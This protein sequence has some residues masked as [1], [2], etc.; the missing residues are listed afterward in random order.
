MTRAYNTATTQQNSGGA[1]PTFNAGKNK[2]ING[3]FA[4]WQRNTTFTGSGAIYTAD[5]F[6]GLSDASQTY[7]R[8]AFTPGAAPVTGY[9]SQYFWRA[10]KAATGTYV[11]LEQFIEDVTTF[12]GQ[13]MT[14]SIWAKA[15]SAQTIYARVQQNFGSGGSTTV[16]LTAQSASITTSWARYSFT[17]AVPSISGKT[18][19]TSSFLAIEFYDVTAAAVTLDFW[20]AQVEAGSVAT[21]FTTASGSLAGEFVLCQRYYQKSYPIE[22][23]PGSYF[24]GSFSLAI[25]QANVPDGVYYNYQRLLTRMRVAPTPVV[26][27]ASGALNKMTT[28]SAADLAN[29]SAVPNSITDTGFGI[30]NSS[31]GALTF[32]SGGYLFNYT[33]SAE[34]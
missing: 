12:A 22:V 18:I 29:N 13:T 14:V 7:S 32:S 4:I 25:I 17:F 33:A 23:V 21:P 10:T 9:E 31:G 2:I 5:R 11:Q 24:V 15:N 19:G 1:T 6:R 8:Q 34:L 20:G 27:S 3:D 16:V 30:T 28:V 26:Y